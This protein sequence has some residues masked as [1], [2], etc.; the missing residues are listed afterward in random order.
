MK[1][2]DIFFKQFAKGL[3]KYEIENLYYLASIGE[4]TDFDFLD[5]EEY[6]LISKT[7][8]NEI[9]FKFKIVELFQNWRLGNK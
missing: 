5:D 1:Y 4:L 2:S 6:D 7:D 8:N 9:S 3:G